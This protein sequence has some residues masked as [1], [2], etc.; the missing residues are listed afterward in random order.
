MPPPWQGAWLCAATCPRLP[1]RYLRKCWHLDRI[2]TASASLLTPLP[3]ACHRVFFRSSPTSWEGDTVLGEG[4]DPGTPRPV[5]S[6]PAVGYCLLPSPD[7]GGTAATHQGLFSVGS[8]NSALPVPC[9]SPC[10][11][12]LLLMQA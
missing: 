7:A 8:L 1:P 10:S 9:V 5:S 11:C 2:N 3:L 4:S 12:S 6:S